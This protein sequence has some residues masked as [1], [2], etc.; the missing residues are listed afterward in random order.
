MSYAIIGL[1]KIGTAIAQA[2]AHQGIEVAVA[3]RRPV[4]ALAAQIGPSLIPQRVE[5]AVKA[6]VVILAMPFAAHREI[7]RAA[8]TGKG[9][10]SSTPPMRLASHPRSWVDCPQPPPLHRYYP[11]RS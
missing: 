6:D 7:A 5:D 1:G 10:S 11:A 4:D 8:K 2:F 9:R 3:G